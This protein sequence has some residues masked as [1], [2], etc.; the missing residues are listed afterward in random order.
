MAGRVLGAWSYGQVSI[1]LLDC[2]AVSRRSTWLLTKNVCLGA[3][4][5]EPCA[6]GLGLLSEPLELAAAGVGEGGG[7]GEP[8]LDEIRVEE[9][10]VLLIAVRISNLNRSSQ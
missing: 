6:P 8:Q 3:S 2:G 7:A 5:P 9:V 10:L 4:T 1:Y